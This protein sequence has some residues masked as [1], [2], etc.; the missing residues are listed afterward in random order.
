MISRFRSRALAEFW[1][2][3]DRSGI[4][5]DWVGRVKLILDT[6]HA[7][8]QPGDMRVPGFKFHPLKGEREGTYAVTV[9]RNWRVTFCFRDGDA[10]DIDLEDYH[11][12]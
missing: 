3:N 5:A 6:L 10:V 7:A 2:N 1:H 11:D 4:R 9:S 12:G 8:R